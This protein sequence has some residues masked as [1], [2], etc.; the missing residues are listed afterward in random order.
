MTEPSEA[1]A[2]RDEVE[3]EVIEDP[4]VSGD[5]VGDKAAESAFRGRS[6]EIHAPRWL[7]PSEGPSQ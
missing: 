4:G 6:G 2:D 5:D 3:P 7:S 1:A